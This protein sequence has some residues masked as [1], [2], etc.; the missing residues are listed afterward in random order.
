[1]GAQGAI[2]HM[3]WA[4]L[5]SAQTALAGCGGLDTDLEVLLVCMGQQQG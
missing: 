5:R 4:L 3:L 1:M 2:P